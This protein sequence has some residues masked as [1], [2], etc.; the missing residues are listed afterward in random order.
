LLRSFLV[1]PPDERQPIVQ[2]LLSY[3]GA[4]PYV[5]PVLQVADTY[6]NF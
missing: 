5:A 3:P 4:Q 6:N 1:S 2:E